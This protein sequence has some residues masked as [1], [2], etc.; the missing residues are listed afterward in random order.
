MPSAEKG[1]W[2]RQDE[3]F[4]REVARKGIA[5]GTGWRQ[6]TGFRQ[7]IN[8]LLTSPLNGHSLQ[9]ELTGLDPFAFEPI[10]FFIASTMMRRASILSCRT[11]SQCL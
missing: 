11:A 10:E 2:I 5:R 3:V 4:G 9:F 8:A 1:Q 7:G 6:P